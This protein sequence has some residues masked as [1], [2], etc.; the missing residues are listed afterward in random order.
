M[1]RYFHVGTALLLIAT[2]LLIV[3][4]VSN[5]VT[6]DISLMKIELTNSSTIRRS[7]ILAGVFGTW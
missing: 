4:S 6:T 3:A 7:S 5:P 1:P 2:A